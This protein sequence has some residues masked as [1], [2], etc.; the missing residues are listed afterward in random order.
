MKTSFLAFCAFL[1]PVMAQAYDLADHKQILMQAMSEYNQCAPAKLSSWN[2]FVILNGDLDEDTNLLRKDTLYSHF[3]HPLKKLDMFRYDASV[4]LKMLQKNLATEVT[5]DSWRGYMEL[6]WLGGITHYLQDVT[7]PPHIIPVMHTG[8]G[9]GF[10]SYEFNGDISSGWSCEQGLAA[11]AGALPENLLKDTAS[12]TLYNINAIHVEVRT[13]FFLGDMLRQ[14]T[15]EDFWKEAPDRGFGQYGVLGNHFGE[16]QFTE[17]DV[18]YIVPAEFYASFKQQQMRLAV[19]SSLKALY[20][21]ATL[22]K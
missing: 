4:R 3:Y 12:Q 14:V 21:Y 13:R 15:G 2:Q 5:A 17:N 22:N 19:Q 6:S 20:W 11:A 10:E 18:T 1:L 7:A 9:D 8:W 16:T